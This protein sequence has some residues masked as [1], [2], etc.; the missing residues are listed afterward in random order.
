MLGYIR[1]KFN[2]KSPYIFSWKDIER[3]Q[4][5]CQDFTRKSNKKSSI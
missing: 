1:R 2:K 3:C 5:G 4:K